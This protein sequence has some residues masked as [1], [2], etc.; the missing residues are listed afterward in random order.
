MGRLLF[1]RRFGWC[2]IAAGLE[3]IHRNGL[4]HRDL[5]PNNIWVE[6]PGGHVKLLD[7]GLVRSLANNVRLTDAGIIVGTPA[8]MSPEQARGERLDA[9]SDLFSFGGV[10]YFLCSKQM[11][12]AAATQVGMLTAVVLDQ[13]LPIGELNPELP[14]PIASLIMQLLEKN[15][16]NRPISA[17]EVIERL[18]AIEASGAF[19]TAT[20]PVS[21]TSAACGE[22]SD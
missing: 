7:F 6:E 1:P 13:P 18:D 14:Q 21:E 12:F 2:E 3:V 10:L 20:R 5:K 16:E 19:T 22:I 11:P 15:V 17:Q 9:R 4:I 8:F